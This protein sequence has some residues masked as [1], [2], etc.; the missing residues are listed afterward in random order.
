MPV[1]NEKRYIERSLGAVL[2]QDYPRDRLEILIA[3]GMSDDGTRQLIERLAEGRDV[4]VIDNPRGIV[5]PGLNAVIAEARGEIIVRVDG[6]CEIG[7]G[8]VRRA[9]EYLQ[10]EDIAGAGGPVETVGET[11]LARAIAAAMSSRFGVGDS[12]FRTGTAEPVHADTIP[13]PAY[14]RS[15]LEAAGPFDE[16]LVRNQDDEYNYRLRGMGGK[17]LLA[18][19]LGSRY[20]S[21]A[22]LRSLARQY[23]Q[24]GFWKVRVMQ[25]HPRQMRLR[26]FA[27]PL[28]AGGLVLGA[29]AAAW[30]LL[31]LA[32]VGGPYLLALLAASLWATRSTPSRS[33]P[34][35]PAIF[36]ALHL[37]YG[38]GFLWGLL[39]FAGRWGRR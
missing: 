20:Y 7:P 14:P 31:L 13:F 39:R 10:D 35:L 21:R 26:Q 5:A 15:V 27:P 37:G 33:W 9:V 34:L 36:A 28:L 32:V 11:P 3:D 1:R 23:F 38:S 24:Y 12:A 8:H 2:A 18:P 6:H 25:K 22:G 19:D 29:L 30:T 4:R 16:E 17:L